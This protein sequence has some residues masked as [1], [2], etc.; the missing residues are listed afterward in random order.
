MKYKVICSDL[1]GTLLDSESRLSPEN[2]AAISEL[3]KR[4]KISKNHVSVKLY[5]ARRDLKKLLESE[6]ISI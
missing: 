1:D 5:R 4:F 6:G 2:A 3:A